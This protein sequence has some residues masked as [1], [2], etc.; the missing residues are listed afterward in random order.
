MFKCKN[1]LESVPVT[2]SQ[3]AEKLHVADPSGGLFRAATTFT[4][5]STLVASGAAEGG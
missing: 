4:E 1:P 5:A 3:A 2:S